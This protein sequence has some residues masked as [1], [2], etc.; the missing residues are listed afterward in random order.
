MSDNDPVPPTVSFPDTNGTTMNTAVTVTLASGATTWAYRINGSS[1]TT[2]SATLFTLQ[3][4]S[5]SINAV[6]VRNSDAAGNTSP[7]TNNTSSF[8]VLDRRTD[9]LVCIIQ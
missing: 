6:Q 5:Y 3:P 9:K 1:W 4:G 2:G 8:T 7:S